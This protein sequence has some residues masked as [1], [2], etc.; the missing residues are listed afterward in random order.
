MKLWYS[1]SS[2]YARK[3]RAVVQYHQLQDRVE[4]L[5]TTSGL[6]KNSPHNLD[7]PL[8]RLPA[9]QRENGEW[10]YN[11]SLI[12]EYLDNIASQRNDSAKK[13]REKDASNL[14]IHNEG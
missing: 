1:N 7:N 12:A 3:A 4:L 13:K 6:D 5:L 8:G 9:L 14:E 2:P 11:S 10:L